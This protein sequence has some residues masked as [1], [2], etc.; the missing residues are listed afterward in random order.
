M[1]PVSITVRKK[2]CQE[3]TSPCPCVQV[4]RRQIPT[5]RITQF[6]KQITPNK[7]EIAHSDLLFATPLAT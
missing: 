2:S 5:N 6:S 3:N 4:D 1:I 7:N